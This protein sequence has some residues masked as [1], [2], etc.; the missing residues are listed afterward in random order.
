[1][2][3]RGET[4]DLVL[5]MEIAEYTDLAFAFDADSRASFEYPESETKATADKIASIAMT[6]MSSAMVKAAGSLLFGTSEFM[7]LRGNVGWY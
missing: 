2:K 1:M 3:Y 7:I 6:T 4:D 5:S